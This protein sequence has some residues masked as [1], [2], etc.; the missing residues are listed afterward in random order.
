MKNLSEALGS[1]D[2]NPRTRPPLLRACPPPLHAIPI[3]P[4]RQ[5]PIDD[6]RECGQ[7]TDN[8]V[9]A[10]QFGRRRTGPMTNS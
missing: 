4:E 8:L 9:P 6:R 5:S 3:P 7:E 2:R 10:E 1:K